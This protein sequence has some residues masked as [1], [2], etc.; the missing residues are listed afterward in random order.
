MLF[1]CKMKP[2]T[3]CL[4]EMP[5]AAPRGRLQRGVAN[6]SAGGG[7]FARLKIVDKTAVFA[8]LSNTAI[9]A[10]SMIRTHVIYCEW[11]GKN[12]KATNSSYI[13]SYACLLTRPSSK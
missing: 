3:T 7:G 10:N 11:L 1:L 2:N 12:N 8:V 4:R 13:I 5:P 6:G 9:N